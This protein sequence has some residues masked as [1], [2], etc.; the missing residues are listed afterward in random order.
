MTIVYLNKCKQGY[1]KG[2]NYKLINNMGVHL[3]L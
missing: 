3:Q 1:G 2:S